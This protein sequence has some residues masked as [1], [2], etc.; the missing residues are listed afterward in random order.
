MSSTTRRRWPFVLLLLGSLAWLGLVAG[1][2]LGAAW[3]VPEGSGLAG[4]AVALGYGVV[5]TAGGLV[6]GG[7]LGWKASIGALRAAAMAA[8]LLA[9]LAAGLLA[10]R[11]AAVQADA[12]IFPTAA[13][14]RAAGP[15]EVALAGYP[16]RVVAR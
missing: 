14:I 16:Y 3:L 9:L 4:P 2:A 11:I 15:A 1:T 5:G 8:V 6:L 13:T 10:W 12:G 7:V